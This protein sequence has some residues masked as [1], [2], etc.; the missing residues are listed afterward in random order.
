MHVTQQEVSHIIPL[1]IICNTSILYII[2]CVAMFIIIK[3]TI[4]T[5][6]HT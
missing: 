4:Y 5:H 1:Q 2:I 6:T 3:Q